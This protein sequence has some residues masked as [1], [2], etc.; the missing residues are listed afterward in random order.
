M[1]CFKHEQSDRFIHCQL[2]PFEL[3]LVGWRLIFSEMLWF[4][5][6][7][8]P[9]WEIRQLKK[10]LNK[11]ICRLG[12]LVRNKT[13]NSRDMLDLKDPELDLALGQLELM[14]D[15]IAS[16]YSELEAKRARFVEERREKYTKN[17][18]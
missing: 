13:E 1:T 12:A 14:E 16:L 9:L 5:K 18:M 11:E 2:G 10:R 17:K 4:F 6:T 8:W 15:E 3:F 7:R